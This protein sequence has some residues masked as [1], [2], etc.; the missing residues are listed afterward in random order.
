[1]FLFRQLAL[2]RKHFRWIA[3]VMVLGGM[4]GGG[5]L[6]FPQ[7]LLVVD[8]GPVKGDV[9]VVLG[10]GKGER[11]LRAAELYKAGA[12]PWILC[13]GLGD[14][15]ANVQRLER[16]GVPAAAILREELS[17]NT[18]ENARFSLPIL[19]RLG[20]KR[21]IIVT[22]W[23]HSRRARQ[24]F[25]HYGPDLS[26][27][28]RPAYAGCPASRWAPQAISGHVKSEYL[29]LMGYWARYGVFPI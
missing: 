6:F 24:V 21:V 25:R 26:I 3:A 10:G 17:R 14:C 15:D 12:A 8:S 28:S 2:V 23:Y 4:I 27:Y 18:S 9:L 19:R 13:S 5:G 20:A 22:S 7:Q 16:A 1:M 11:P 29:K